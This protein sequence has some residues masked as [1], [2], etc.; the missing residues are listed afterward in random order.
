MPDDNKDYHVI[1]SAS[2]ILHSNRA[3][4]RLVEI[5]RD[6]PGIVIFIHG[7]KIRVRCTR[8]SRRG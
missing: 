5:P 6:L 7:V 3:G 2:G 1:A 4:D 8:P